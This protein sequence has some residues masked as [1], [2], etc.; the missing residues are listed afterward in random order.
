[1]AR[2]EGP[3]P[4]FAAKRKPLL[5]KKMRTEGDRKETGIKKQQGGLQLNNIKNQH[6]IGE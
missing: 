2:E 5:A 1:L 3:N 4:S 6:V